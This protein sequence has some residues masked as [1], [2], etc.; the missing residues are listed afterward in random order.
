ML[1]CNKLRNQTLEAT[2]QLTK[3]VLLVFISFNRSGRGKRVCEMHV[4]FYRKTKREETIWE[5]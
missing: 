3:S 2:L 4:Q 1:G 5:T